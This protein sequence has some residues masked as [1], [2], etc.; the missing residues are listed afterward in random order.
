MKLICEQ[1]V[2]LAFDAKNVNILN[3]LFLSDLF[4]LFFLTCFL[5]CASATQPFK[6]VILLLSY[7]L[8]FCI[9]VRKYA[10]NK[11]GFYGNI[12]IKA[13]LEVEKNTS[14]MLQ[15]IPNYFIS[16]EIE[17]SAI[18]IDAKNSIGF[19]SAIFWGLAWTSR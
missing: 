16:I 2:L 11:T 9:K 6:P 3:N 17:I 12:C 5:G 13:C 18:V 8:V 19:F 14:S 4:C 1:F 10:S 15:S 7:L